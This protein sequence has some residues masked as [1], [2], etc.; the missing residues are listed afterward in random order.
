M[1]TSIVTNFIMNRVFF[2]ILAGVLVLFIVIFV[3]KF[4]SSDVKNEQGDNEKKMVEKERIQRFWDLYRQATEHRIAGRLQRAAEDYRSAL[5][6]NDHHEDA[7]YYLGNVYLELGDFRGAEHAWRRLVQVNSNSARAHFQLGNLHLNFEHKEFFDLNKAEA[8]FERAL[9]INKEETG[10]LLSLGQVALIRG[11]LA[12]A[13]RYFNAV[14]GSN[15]KSVEAHFLNGYIAWKTGNSQ[16]ALTLLS[17]AV[18][19]SQPEKPVQGVLGEGDTKIGPP[20]GMSNR[21]KV[22]LLDLS[23]LNE[24]SLLQQM[25]SKYQILDAYLDQIRSEV[26]S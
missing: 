26:Q 18:K 19:Y 17:K 7:L 24:S 3:L 15:Y 22:D 5:T 20:I 16:K 13:R 21:W 4:Q 9:E 12:E 11:N 2:T 23:G 8:E 6:I 1:T 10:P 14:T 25:E